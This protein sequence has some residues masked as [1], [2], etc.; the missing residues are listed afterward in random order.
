MAIWSDPTARARADRVPAVAA[1]VAAVAAADLG[2]ALCEIAAL[3]HEVLPADVVAVRVVDETEAA[4][5]RT[6]HH[7]GPAPAAQ[8]LEP[9][10]RGDG[11]DPIA[12]GDAARA[13]GAPVTWPRVAA[14]AEHVAR[15]AE[16]AGGDGRLGALHRALFDAAGVA[17]PLTLPGEP[18]VGSTTLIALSGEAALPPDAIAAL[19]ALTPQ[20]ALVARNHQLAVRSRRTRR[21]LE[22]VIASI[23]V[24]VIVSDVRGRLSLAN[25]AAD[26]LVGIELGAHVGRPITAVV[27]E[28]VKWRF[29]NPEEYAARFLAIHADPEAEVTGSVDTVAGRVVEH[30]SAPVRDEDGGL[31]G[32]V[33]ILHDVTATRHALDDARRLAEERAMLLDREERRA[34]EEAD[35]ARAAQALASAMSPAEIHERL[36]DEAHHFVAGCEKGAV[37]TVDRRGLVLPAATRNFGEATVEQLTFRLGSGTVGRMLESGRPLICNDTAVDDRISTRITGPEGIRSFMLVP[38]MHGGRVLGLVSVNCLQP[39]EFG[40]RE[41]RILTELARHAAGALAN[42]LEFERE[43][44]IAETLQQALIADRLPDVPGLELA[45]RYQAAAGSLVGGDF[46]SAWTLPDDRLAVL[47]G[48]VSGKGVDAAG[49]TAMARYMAEALSQHRPEPADV[50]GELNDLMCPRLADGA[51]VTLVLTVVD[52]ARGELRWC[53][54]GHPPPLLVGAGGTM[55]ALEDPCPP[56]GV[57]PGERYR[58]STEPFGPGDALVLYTDGLIEARRRLREFGEDGLRRALA[59]AAGLDPRGVVGALHAAACDWRGGRLTDDV[60]IAVVR[61]T[62]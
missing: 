24:G 42:A 20:I 36:L 27:D 25:R 31:L 9:L 54:A 32:R 47:V 35:L 29:T 50:V 60:A 1:R 34:Q 3:V 51:L 26:E 52:T 6:G 40:E 58:Q 17:V 28:Q 55:R 10:L 44:H 59:D 43:R 21:T 12:I 8:A 61:R 18:P 56:C 15:L 5:H 49:V 37:L 53:C 30:S 62:A 46:Y 45:A 11:P 4:D 41:V 22:G 39:R 38:L 13:A 33:D 23:P 14:E 48:D 19:T 7:F 2:A 57:F 16:L